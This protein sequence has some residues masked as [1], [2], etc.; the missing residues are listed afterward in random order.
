ML[1]KI[2]E[3]N[4]SEDEFEKMYKTNTDRTL[5]I[6]RFIDYI[7]KIKKS[8]FLE[9]KKDAICKLE[10]EVAV[11]YKKYNIG[12]M[13]VIKDRIYLNGLKI[14]MSEHKQ[15]SLEKFMESQTLIEAMPYQEKLD[16]IRRKRNDREGGGNI[17]NFLQWL[18]VC[19]TEVDF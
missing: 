18:D 2:Y 3:F 7:L 16:K 13:E 15:T 6:C 17:K 4:I 14:E 19:S 9:E 11:Y 10:N 1:E 5:S 12:L 8:C